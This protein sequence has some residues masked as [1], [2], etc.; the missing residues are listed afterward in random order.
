MSEKKEVPITHAVRFIFPLINS[1][2]TC[3]DRAGKP[4]IIGISLFNKSWGLPCEETDPAFGVYYIMVH[5]ARYSHQLIEETGEYVINIPTGDIIEE[6][7]YCGTRSGRKFDKFKE[8][9]LTPIPAKVVKPPLIKE[10]PVNIECK[11]VEKIKPMH[12]KY[13]FFFGKAV[14]VHADEGVWDGNIVNLEKCPMPLVACAGRFHESQFIAPGKVI[15]K[16]G[17]PL[18]GE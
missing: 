13:T 10:C 1:L 12:S 14:A 11:V 18:K 16:N 5:P 15:F 8:T 17:R 6:T 4:N 2:V 3:V 7:W 9:K